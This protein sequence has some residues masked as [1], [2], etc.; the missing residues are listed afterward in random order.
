LA[1]FATTIK[2][3]AFKYIFKTFKP[4]YVLYFDNDIWVVDSFHDIISKLEHRSVITTPH[5]IKPCPEDGKGHRDI[6]IL[7]AGVM[8]FGF[9]GFRHTEASL[10]FIQWW[11]ERLRYYGYANLPEGLFPLQ[12]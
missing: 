6:H 10:N 7:K 5:I 11:L 1:E 9:V 3:I 4:E 12:S 8:N 2:P